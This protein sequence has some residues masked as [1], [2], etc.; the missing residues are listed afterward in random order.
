MSVRYR[1]S[2]KFSDGFSFDGSSQRHH[3]PTSVVARA[4]DL[5][6]PNSLASLAM[7]RGNV[8][9]T[10]TLKCSLSSSLVYKESKSLRPS[11]SRGI[12]V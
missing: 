3:R 1:Q 6:A 11:N 7:I 2:F 4:K 8:C 10:K 9:D 12:I 5:Q